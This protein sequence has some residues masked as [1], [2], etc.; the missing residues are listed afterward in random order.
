MVVVGGRA[1]PS[2]GTEWK[3]SCKITVHH[4]NEAFQ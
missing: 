4:S 3:P 2:K 1:K